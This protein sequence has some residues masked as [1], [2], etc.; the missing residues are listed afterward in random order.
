MCKKCFKIKNKMV[1]LLEYYFKYEKRLCDIY[2]NFS[3]SDNIF[4]EWYE[5]KGRI[6]MLEELI[7]FAESVGD[8]NGKV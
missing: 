1:E 6:K 4:K 3:H 8:K 2:C 7:D 5:V